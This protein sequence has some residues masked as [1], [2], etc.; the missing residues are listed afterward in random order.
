[1]KGMKNKFTPERERLALVK[2]AFCHV[3][4]VSTG[5]VLSLVW[6]GEAFVLQP[7]FLSFPLD[8]CV[9]R[10]LATSPA[11]RH[12]S[13]SLVHQSP[14]RVVEWEAKDFKAVGSQVA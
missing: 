1:M 8:I 5:P 4:S 10:N 3:E 7:L 6:K 13:T 2:A 9:G 11:L 14:E 12:P